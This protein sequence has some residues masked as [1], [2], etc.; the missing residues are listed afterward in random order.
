M[1]DGGG[2]CAVLVPTTKGIWYPV[3][4]GNW[5]EHLLDVPPFRVYNK[6]MLT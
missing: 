3:I 1:M 4:S 2:A 5:P 6:R